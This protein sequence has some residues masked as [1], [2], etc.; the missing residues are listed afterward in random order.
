MFILPMI[1]VSPVSEQTANP[2]LCP[3]L[4]EL[5]NAELAAGNSV[6]EYRTGL[7]AAD[8]VLVRLAKAFRA[9][10]KNM[11]AGVEYREVNDPH[12]WKAEYFRPATKH[13]IACGF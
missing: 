9:P 10:P 3:E 2:R 1:I 6:V 8:A 12:W 7:Y 4:R 13:C 5:L 11:P